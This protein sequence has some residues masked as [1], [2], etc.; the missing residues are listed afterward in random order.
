MYYS[1]KY[2]NDVKEGSAGQANLWFIKIRPEY[3]GDIGLLAH[4][5]VHTE[6]FWKTLGFHG[7]LYWLSKSYKLKCEVEAYREQLKWPPAT[8]DRPHYAQHYAEFIAQ[9][10]GLSIPVEEALKLLNT[11]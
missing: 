10:Y 5:V 7:L 4:E 1:L 9:K 2:T 6:Q 11:K 3:K 8:E